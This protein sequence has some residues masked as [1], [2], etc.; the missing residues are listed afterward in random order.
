MSA[1]TLPPLPE[2]DVCWV[3]G[4]D[5]YGYATYDD[6]HSAKQMTEYGQLCRADLISLIA[7]VHKAK[8]RYHSQLAM[9]DLY[10]AVG[11]AN[12]RPEKTKEK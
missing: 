10:D 4:E 12:T 7:A 5:K 3:D 8:G 11:L 9:C 6:A 1:G 2:P